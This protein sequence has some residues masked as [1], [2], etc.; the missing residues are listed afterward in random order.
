MTDVLDARVVDHHHFLGTG[1]MLDM[2]FIF[3]CPIFLKVTRTLG[4]AIICLVDITRFVPLAVNKQG[5]C[6]GRQV[7]K[8]LLPDL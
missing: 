8:H 6:D 5:Q 1:T 3:I 7:I 2:E 4:T